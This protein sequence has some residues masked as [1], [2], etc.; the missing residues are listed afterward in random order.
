MK[1]NFFIILIS[2]LFSGCNENKKISCC[3]PVKPISTFNLDMSENLPKEINFLI[4]INDALERYKIKN[5]EYPAFKD[6]NIA[7]D[8]MFGRAISYENQLFKAIRPYCE[9]TCQ[10]L[11]DNSSIQY[12]TGYISNGA[13]YKLLLFNKNLCEAIKMEYPLIINPQTYQNCS[14][15]G[16]WTSRATYW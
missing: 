15:V 16:F 11:I 4:Q 9:K 13:Q 5:F 1:S 2:F 12:E 10:N 6:R 14:S 8:Q 3:N 7:N